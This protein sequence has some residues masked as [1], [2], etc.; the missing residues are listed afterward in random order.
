[1]RTDVEENR[2]L[3]RIVAEKINQSTGPVRVLIPLGGVSQLDSIDREFWWPEADQSLFN[4]LKE[5]L[6]TDI[7]VIELENN[8]ND[9]TFAQ[10]AAQ[11]LLELLG[12]RVSQQ[13]ANSRQSV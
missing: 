9:A 1:M 6:R 12:A 13:V 8:I 11:E 5:H 2:Q 7:P 10:R 4:S 3:G